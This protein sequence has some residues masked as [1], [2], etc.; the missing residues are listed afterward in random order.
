MKTIP[1]WTKCLHWRINIADVGNRSC[2]CQRGETRRQKGDPVLTVNQPFGVVVASPEEGLQ[3]SRSCGGGVWPSPDSSDTGSTRWLLGPLLLPA[4]ASVRRL[5]GWRRVATRPVRAPTLCLCVFA[6][7]LPSSRAAACATKS[8]HFGR[9]SNRRSPVSPGP[10][11]TC[12]HCPRTLKRHFDFLK[13]KPRT[14]AW[15]PRPLQVGSNRQRKT[16]SLPPHSDA[17]GS[18]SLLFKGE[19]G[20]ACSQSRGL[21]VSMIGTRGARG[22]VCSV[23]ES[24]PHLLRTRVYALK[25]NILTIMFVLLQFIFYFMRNKWS[26]HTGQSSG[27]F[28]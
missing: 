24:S 12:Q 17:P 28:F 6:A 7:L 25:E 14:H 10:Q 5:A 3:V 16:S 11:C 15:R 19:V 4:C 1:K 8:V 26:K 23:F 20:S 13:K 18:P 21:H 27:S 22:T 2:G 9:P